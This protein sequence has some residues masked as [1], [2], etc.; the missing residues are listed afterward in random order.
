MGKPNQQ[1]GKGEGR[2]KGEREESNT[3]YEHNH[4]PTCCC[5]KPI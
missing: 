3:C 2:G 1:R 5:V 4:Y